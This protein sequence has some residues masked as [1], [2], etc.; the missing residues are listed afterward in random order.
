V[1]SYGRSV[2]HYWYS[3]SVAHYG[4]YV[5]PRII[6]YTINT[7]HHFVIV[8]SLVPESGLLSNNA[9]DAV[10]VD[11][12]THIAEHEIGRCTVFIWQMV[13]GLFRE[14]TYDERVSCGRKTKR[15]TPGN[16]QISG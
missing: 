8:T 1:E 2:N 12:W 3:R 16:L 11:Q 9:K 4:Q 13:Q 7:V 6:L 5:G 10:L 15:F 14:G